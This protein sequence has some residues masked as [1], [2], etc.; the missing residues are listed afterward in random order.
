MKYG[1]KY[2]HTKHTPYIYT[3]SFPY[4]LRTRGRVRGRKETYSNSFIEKSSTLGILQGH[5]FFLM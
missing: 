5:G 4:F 3:S 1:E 2:C